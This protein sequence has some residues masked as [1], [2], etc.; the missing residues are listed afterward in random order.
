MEK[1][2]T[3]FKLK[4]IA[5]IIGII[6]FIIIC[7]VQTY[8]FTKVIDMAPTQENIDS[9]KDSTQ[10]QYLENKRQ[11]EEIQQLIDEN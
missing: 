8:N 1:E 7:K 11:I 4:L 10:K 6:V 5:G 2:K 9:L 3:I